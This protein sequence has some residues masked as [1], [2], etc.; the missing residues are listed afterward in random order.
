MRAISRRTMTDPEPL[1][2][3]ARSAGASQA[4]VYAVQTEETPVRFEA[5]RLK[6]LNARHTS[7]VAVRVIVDGRIGFASSTRPGD[8]EDVVRAAVETAPF[9]PEAQFD[10]PSNG[11][12]PEVDV[13]DAATEALSVDSMIETGQSLVDAA[14]AIEP[15]LLCD[16]SVRRAV[17]TGTIANS[18]GGQFT[19]KGTSLMAWLHGTLVRGTDMLFVGDGDASC[20]TNLALDTI[21]ASVERQLGHSRR[22]AE[23]RTAEL[24][25]VFTPIGVAEALA[26]PLTVAFSGRAVYL[27]QSPLV[28]CLGKEMYDTRFSMTDDPLLPGRVASRPFDDEGV[29]SRALPLVEAGV[30]R[31]L[32]YDL[33]TAGLAKT[34]STGAA[35]RSLASQP[36]ISTSSLVIEAGDTTFDEMVKGIDEGLVV[37]EL[38]GAGQ[39]N[40]MGGDFSGNVLLG[41]KIDGGEIV[42]R[43]KDAI[44]AG[45]VH[46]A[47]KRIVAI[48]SETRW[49]GGTMLTPPIWF[50]RLTV[51]AKS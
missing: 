41:Y 36:Q 17:A 28:G 29:A 51:S 33:Q 43:V 7:G 10:F 6:E 4:E 18:N 21:K 12:P 14:R 40:V 2:T 31:N 9:G 19:Y 1:L 38:M 46:E 44:V 27:G 22:T 3:A 49:V 25:V 16:A 15:E 37:E 39:G 23:V 32:M 30:V 34:G 50:E 45:N 20:G 11:V 24:P 5:N 48:G 8:V 42:G 35:S 47:I 13:F 26:M